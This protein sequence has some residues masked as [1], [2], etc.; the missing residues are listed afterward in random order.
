MQKKL[1]G[2]MLVALLMFATMACD[3]GISEEDHA[4]AVDA[5]RAEGLAAGQAEAVA[6]MEAVS[7][8]G[9]SLSEWAIS[10]TP[11][12]IPAGLVRITAANGGP[13][14]PHELVIFKTDLSI[15]DL[16]QVAI[17]NP[18]ERGFL[19]EA[20]VPGAEFIGEIEE[21]EPGGVETG[22]FDLAPGRYVFIC[23]IVEHS[24]VDEQGNPESHLLEG[25]SMEF[26]VR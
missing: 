2:L 24:E 20:D 11:N 19:P 8:V 5:A 23:N 9:V 18:E 26:I 13:V 15:E 22:V 25:M 1:I 10:A 12:S 21:F 3:S 7:S 14:D 4:A 16:E 6:G 17:A